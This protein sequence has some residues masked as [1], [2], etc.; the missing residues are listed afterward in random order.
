MDEST[1]GLI[2]I[3]IG[4]M[5]LVSEAFQPGFFIAIPGTVLLCLGLVGVI[6]PDI[7][8]TWVSPVIALLISI[9]MTVVTIKLYEKLAPP[10]PPT[11]TVGTSLIGQHGTVTVEVKPKEITGKVQVEHQLWSATSSKVI[12][13]GTDVKIVQSRGVHVVVEPLNERRD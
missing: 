3:L 7:F 6:A 12:P 8:F 13:V 9:P 4:I 11:T 2:L 5:M 1:I 10:E